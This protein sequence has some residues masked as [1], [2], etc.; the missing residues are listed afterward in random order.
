MFHL[1][2]HYAGSRLAA[3]QVSRD[4]LPRLAMTTRSCG[5]GKRRW[6]GLVVVLCAFTAM[7]AGPGAARKQIEASM[8]VTGTIKVGAQGEVDSF[9]LDKAEKLPAGVVGF[10]EKNIARW[11]FEPAMVNGQAVGLRNRMSLRVVAKELEGNDYL[12]ELR[13]VS[14]D[15]FEVQ[16]DHEITSKNLT[17]P[18]YPVG[19]AMSG[20]SGTVY[21]ILKVGRDGKVEDA[22]AEQ[23]NLRFIDSE[24]KMEHW[25][26]MLAAASLRAAKNWEFI[27]PTK[28]E[29]AAEEFWSV[30]VPVDYNFHQQKQP[31]YGDWAAYVPGPRQS[32]SWSQHD[33]PGFSPDALP[34]SGIFL[35]SGDGLRLLTPLNEG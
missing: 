34:E 18:R 27:P 16:K 30:R 11:K 13:A 14:F 12:V 20:V 4:T 3:Q 22:V 10:L 31:K 6:M 8:L 23:V 7:A 17:P 28:G 1:W 35:A 33:A 2:R 5:M 15:P 19:A 26:E 32:Y 25:R 29:Y 9:D 24:R 21:L